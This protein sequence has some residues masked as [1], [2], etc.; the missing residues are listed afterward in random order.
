[1]NIIECN[2]QEEI[3]QQV[4]N[5]KIVLKDTDLTNSYFNKTSL[6][7]IDLTT[8]EISGIDLEIDDI[9]GAIVTAIQALDL[10]RM[11][12]LVIKC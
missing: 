2:F 12:R 4:K 3:F 1:M 7:K 8:C 9:G 10:T 5:E 11:M 6:D